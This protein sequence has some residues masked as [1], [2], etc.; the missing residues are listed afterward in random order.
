MIHFLTQTYIT[1]YCYYQAFLLWLYQFFPV[2]H[3]IYI[4]DNDNIIRNIT[5]DYYLRKYIESVVSGLLYT[6]D[7]LTFEMAARQSLTTMLEFIVPYN[8]PL[9]VWRHNETGWHSFSTTYANISSVK[10]KTL[11]D[12]KYTRR[13]ILLNGDANTEKLD[14][15]VLDDFFATTSAVNTRKIQNLGVIM[16]MFGCHASYVRCIG[17]KFEIDCKIAD[18]QKIENLYTKDLE[19]D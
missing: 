18:E 14:L 1:I 2:F 4:V 6:A 7:D 19:D 16:R 8:Q 5:W 15:Q 13:R 11:T 17:S 10:I 12:I 9:F 3:L